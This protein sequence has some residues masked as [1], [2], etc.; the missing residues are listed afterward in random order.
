M[1]EIDPIADVDLSRHDR[2]AEH[3]PALYC[4]LRKRHCWLFRPDAAGDRETYD[5]LR[6]DERRTNPPGAN[7]WPIAWKAQQRAKERARRRR[8]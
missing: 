5:C 7:E 4:R 3:L 1:S 8:A 6:C 2:L